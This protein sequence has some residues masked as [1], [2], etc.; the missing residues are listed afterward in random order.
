MN[1]LSKD[2][3]GNIYFKAREK[4]IIIRGG[5]NIYPVII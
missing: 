5:V 3:V 2:E 4:E 1:N